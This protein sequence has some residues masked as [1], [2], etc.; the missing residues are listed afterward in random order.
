[1]N[2]LFVVNY[3]SL[4]GG[5]ETWVLRTANALHRLGHV[6]TI[7]CPL[8]DTEDNEFFNKL[9]SSIRLFF[10]NWRRPPL[11]FYRAEKELVRQDVVYCVDLGSLLRS[12]VLIDAHQLNA[13]LVI[14]IFHP[15]EY[16]WR[17]SIRRY[18]QILAEAIL[19]AAPRSN[20]IFMNEA[21]AREHQDC[22]GIDFMSSPIVPLPVDTKKYAATRRENVNRRRIVSVG[23]I[24]NFKTYH[25]AMIDVLL[26]LNERGRRY[27]Y[28]VYGDG[29]LRKALEKY[30]REKGLS[31]QLILHGWMAYE[32]FSASMQEAFL[33]I[34]MGTSLI[35][36]AA[37]G[38]PALTAIDS[39]CSATTYGF[40]HELIGYNVG[41]VDP[42]CQLFDI[43]ERIDWLE[44]LSANN[45][46]EVCEQTKERA[47]R[48]F[49]TD[50]VI[51]KLLKC[52]VEAKEFSFPVTSRMKFYDFLDTWAWRVLRR[53]GFKD[54]MG[55]CRHSR[56]GC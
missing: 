26:A 46:L 36:A 37:C 51:Q 45:Y 6:I 9:D 55:S 23:N 3:S 47:V 4:A 12:L 32:N 24:N 48:D 25:F 5:V 1:M 43:D 18:P 14:G 50:P 22:S 31:D 33:F 30:A 17:S 13:K 19:R 8:S 15:R 44:H 34:G 40:F 54:P 10:M 35:E 52:L 21:N 53:I 11:F 56:A 28:H 29:P 20:L 39:N 16:C 41:E 42:S 2:I 7:A 27:E 49:E 38:V